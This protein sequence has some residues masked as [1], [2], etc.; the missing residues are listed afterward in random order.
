MGSIEGG[1]W[2]QLVDKLPADAAFIQAADYIT[3]KIKA[4]WDRTL[5]GVDI[6]DLADDL[7]LLNAQQLQT[8]AMAQLNDSRD[9]T[10]GRCSDSPDPHHP[11]LTAL[12]HYLAFDE[13]RLVERDHLLHAL[14]SK[15][16]IQPVVDAIET[17]PPSIGHTLLTQLFHCGDP[18]LMD[19]LLQQLSPEKCA[20]IFVDCD[21]PDQET[22]RQLLPFIAWLERKV[23]AHDPDLSFTEE[24][25]KQHLDRRKDLCIGLMRRQKRYDEE[26]SWREQEHLKMGHGA[27]LLADRLE[28]KRY[29]LETPERSHSL[30]CSL[31]A[32]ATPKQ[33]SFKA[34]RQ[35]LVV[36]LQA[37]DFR[38]VVDLMHEAVLHGMSHPQYKGNPRTLKDLE[39]D[40]QAT[41]GD[42][43]PEDVHHEWAMYHLRDQRSPAQPIREG[44]NP[45]SAEVFCYL[46]PSPRQK[47]LTEYFQNLL[48]QRRENERLCASFSAD[49]SDSSAEKKIN[50][51]K[52][53]I[54]LPFQST[55]EIE[56]QWKSRRDACTSSMQ[57]RGLGA[58]YLEAVKAHIRTLKWHDQVGT[59]T[60]DCLDRMLALGIADKFQMPDNWTRVRRALELKHKINRDLT[61]P[62]D[63]ISLTAQSKEEDAKKYTAYDFIE[64]IRE[65]Y[66]IS[67]L[68]Q[69]KSIHPA[70]PEGIPQWFAEDPR[71]ALRFQEF[72]QGV[73]KQLA[74]E[75][76]QRQL[77]EFVKRAR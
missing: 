74:P 42:A 36:A 68:P 9:N 71:R 53:K 30:A 76:A 34:I 18:S 29:S 11:Q 45:G 57:R 12:I 27:A 38:K 10:D 61:L 73:D 6:T 4:I 8:L 2:T 70:W 55:A 56:Q 54:Q 40:R 44:S 33:R 22:G 63:E 23:S 35:D 43:W 16:R 24:E 15:R 77:H 21:R 7:P 60:V 65:K 64:A 59:L 28:R 67:T 72:D 26:L 32:S 69:F 46:L 14:C 62:P 31:K 58:G 41:H 51:L 3:S 52:A 17:L 39:R 20:A 37:Q 5:T 48:E 75:E 19:I 66:Y 25:K 50:E 13:L 47:E 1:H 49:A